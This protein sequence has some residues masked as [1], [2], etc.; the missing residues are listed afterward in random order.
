MRRPC[1]DDIVS[2]GCDVYEVDLQYANRETR[3]SEVLWLRQALHYWARKLTRSSFRE[4]GERIGGKNH[5]T[6][7]HSIKVI[8]RE[9]DMYDDRK[10]FIDKIE[11]QLWL[12]GFTTE[13]IIREYGHEPQ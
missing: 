13:P 9:Y 5:A 12:N 6:V 4:I 7:M 8:N 1:I 3:R 2:A 10:R 11:R